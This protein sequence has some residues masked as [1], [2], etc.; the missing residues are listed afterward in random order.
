MEK[1]CTICKKSKDLSHFRKDRTRKDGY[2]PHCK[3]CQ[4]NY[5][6]IGDSEIRKE[7]ERRRHKEYRDRKAGLLVNELSP[8]EKSSL[9]LKKYFLENPKV[10]K[11]KPVIVNNFKLNC[12]NSKG[13][14]FRSQLE[15]KFSELL[16]KNNISYQ[17]EVLFRLVNGRAKIVDFLIED[18]L[19]VEISGYAFKD[20]QDNFI[21]KMRLLRQST[22]LQILILTYARTYPKLL[23]DIWDGSINMYFDRIDNENRI[24][25]GIKFSK[26]IKTINNIIDHVEYS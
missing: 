1:I 21:Q 13:E 3:E 20:W 9:S 2:H 6:R 23:Q 7:G 18:F 10:L 11:T 5:R 19:I 16:I 25:R 4:K 22:D 8:S 24:I 26:Q 14:L 17:Y 15:V 12:I